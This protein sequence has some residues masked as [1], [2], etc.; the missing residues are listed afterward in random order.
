LPNDKSLVVREEFALTIHN[1]DVVKIARSL[2]WT[3]RRAV[4][5]IKNALPAVMEQQIYLGLSDFRIHPES[6]AKLLRLFRG[7][8]EIQLDD[9]LPNPVGENLVYSRFLEFADFLRECL[10]LLKIVSLEFSGFAIS[11]DQAG[12]I[13]LHYGNDDPE[14]LLEMLDTNL[15][16]FCE[17]FG[18]S[19]LH[20]YG[21]RMQLCVW[22]MVSKV[23]PQNRRNG[24]PDIL[25][26]SDFFDLSSERR[27]KVRRAICEE[28]P[29]YVSLDSDSMR[30]CRGLELLKREGVI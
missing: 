12:W 13:V 20:P 30:A 5:R 6:L 11:V 23:I 27:N 2:R 4:E 3:P 15:D 22:I 21:K 14:R 8:R 24:C 19:N 9:M 10:N 28:L 16:E 7:D 25:D 29:D 26:T 17:I 18:V 1:Q